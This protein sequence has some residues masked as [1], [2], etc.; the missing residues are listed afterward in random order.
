M[1][2]LMMKSQNNFFS[3]FSIIVFQW[4]FPVHV[5][6]WITALLK[7]PANFCGMMS[8]SIQPLTST[9]LLTRSNL[10]RQHFQK[11]EPSFLS[12]ASWSSLVYILSLLLFPFLIRL[13]YCR[14][15]C[16]L[17]WKIGPPLSLSEAFHI[18]SEKFATLLKVVQDHLK[19]LHWVDRVCVS[20]KFLLF[21]HCR[22]T[23][24]SLVPLMTNSTS[25]GGTTL[26]SGLWA[27]LRYWKR[28]QS[29]ITYD[30]LTTYRKLY[31]GFS[32]NPLLEP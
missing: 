15:V 18:L 3:Q 23:Y 13:R 2:Y 6:A 31:M 27:I 9:F 19:L 10:E 14:R 7:K 20:C 5:I 25:N 24:V 21:I 16:C 1:K 29:T 4:L 22:P 12:R 32:K 17:L 8:V 28:R 26:K 30:L 11:A